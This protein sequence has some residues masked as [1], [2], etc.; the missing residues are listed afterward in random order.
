M[1]KENDK[2]IDH[3]VV[4]HFGREWSDYGSHTPSK[5]EH[6]RIFDEYFSIFPFQ[7]LPQDA[8]GFD[9]GCGSGRWADFVAQKCGKLHCVDASP[10]AL[11]VARQLLA[12][13]GNVEFHNAPVSDMPMADGSQDF[14]Y[15][16]GVLHHI[17]DTQSALQDCVRKLKPGAPFL[18]Y[19]YYRFENRPGWFVAIWQ[20]SDALRRVV[21]GLPY[22]LRRAVSDLFA[23]A[24]YWPV[25]RI[26]R[27]VEK[28]GGEVSNF[29]LSGYRDADF[30]TMRNDA[31]DRFGTRLEQRFTRPEI[32]RMMKS[33]GLKDICFR[34]EPP[35]WV[36]LGYRS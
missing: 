1:P 7:K 5:Q 24:I 11:D 21:S 14:G 16:L 17:P 3:Q 13:H 31:L 30:R 23:V 27:F 12:C 19:L 10:E 20:I 18:L 4:E 34:D 2:N 15:S 9:A 36:A 32:T 29:P 25:A 8:E 22:P 28:F 35:Y 33:A 26:A 6:E